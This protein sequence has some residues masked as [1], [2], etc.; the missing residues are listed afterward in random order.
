MLIF[1]NENPDISLLSLYHSSLHQIFIDTYNMPNTRIGN[2]YNKDQGRLEP[3]SYTIPLHRGD[4]P[5]TNNY[6][7]KEIKKL[8][9]P[10][11]EA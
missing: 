11:G 2:G 8:P 3:Y 9:P 10:K 4:S 7:W 1:L 6:R 5:E